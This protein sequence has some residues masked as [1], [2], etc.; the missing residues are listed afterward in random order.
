[1]KLFVLCCGLVGV[2]FTHV[3]QDS[4]SDTWAI[5]GLPKCQWPLQWRHN[6]RDGVSNHRRLDCLLN[7]LLRRRSKRA[8]MLRFTGLCDENPPLNVWMPIVTNVIIY[9]WLT[10]RVA[11]VTIGHSTMDTCLCLWVKTFQGEENYAYYLTH[12]GSNKSTG[13]LYKT[14]QNGIFKKKVFPL[15]HISFNFVPIGTFDNMLAKVPVMVWRQT[16]GGSLTQWWPN[17]LTHVCVNGLQYAKHIELRHS[18]TKMSFTKAFFTKTSGIHFIKNIRRQNPSWWRHQMEKNSALL[19]FCAGN[20]PVTG[21]F[22]AQRPVTRSFDVF[23]DL[24]LNQQL[25]KQWRRLGFETPAR[26]LWRHCNV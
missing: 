21:E 8:S 16:D 12:R 15:L 22:S 1:M 13:I 5:P 11:E 14:Y 19:A 4:L 25:N 3:F 18:F 17:S 10:I 2:Y 24:R 7:R 26:S 20:S 23:V 9:A 6:E